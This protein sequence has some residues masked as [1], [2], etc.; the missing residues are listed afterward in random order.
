MEKGLKMKRK[1]YKM[2]RK[3][4][5]LPLLVLVV[6]LIFSSCALLDSVYFPE[7][8]KEE[9]SFTLDSIPEFDGATPYVTINGNVP[10][11]D[12]EDTS[13]SYEEY[14]PLDYLGRCGAAISCIGIDLMPTEDRGSIGQVKPSGWQTVKY[15]IVDGKYLYNRCHLIG[16]Q[17][18]G[19]NAN[20]KNLITGTR[21]MNV[22][23]MLPFE[24]MVADYI[25]EEP[26]NHVLYRVTPI[27]EGT[28]LVASGVLMEAKSVEDDGEGILFCVYVFNAQPGIVIDYSN[29]KSHLASDSSG[30]GFVGSEDA[31]GLHYDTSGDGVCEECGESAE[32]AEVHTYVLNLKTHKFHK[33]TCS[34]VKTLAEQNKA[35]YKGTREDVLLDGYSPC[36][37]C[38]P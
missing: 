13:K 32:Y 36:G 22:E 11:F 35:I 37:T 30:E 10:F 1:V 21:Y 7:V 34:S 24:N 15:D 33:E 16:F 2:R 28:N 27:Y 31:C 23:G 14:S 29:G 19:E 25:K 18:T 12:S 5:F 20:N 9:E 6:S 26:Q 8:P 4:L 17:L 3:L 38:K